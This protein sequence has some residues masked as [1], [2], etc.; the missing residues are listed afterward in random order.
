MATRQEREKLNR[1]WLKS[2]VDQHQ[3]KLILELLHQKPENVIEFIYKWAK[4]QAGDDNFAPKANE[5]QQKKNDAPQA[6]EKNIPKKNEN[7]QLDN[8]EKEDKGDYVAP[9][10]DSEEEE[11]ADDVP[12]METLMNTNKPKQNMRQSVSAEVYGKFNE[13]HLFRKFF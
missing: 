2:H 3:N 1:E 12:D 4:E 9:E 10:L 7:F 8:V 13:N 6:E 11:E 5:S